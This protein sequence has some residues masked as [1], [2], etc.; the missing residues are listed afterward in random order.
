MVRYCVP[1]LQVSLVLEGETLQYHGGVKPPKSTCA[2]P[3]GMLFRVELRDLVDEGHPLVRLANEVDWD[4][5]EEVFGLT[6]VD[7]VGRCVFRAIPATDSEGNR[8]RVPREF[9]HL[10]RSI[11]AGC[12]EGKRPGYPFDF[13]HPFRGFPAG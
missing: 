7:G 11:P 12:S 5:F 1:V 8:P 3:Q 2:D 6:Y 9:G 10:F 13:G 4:R